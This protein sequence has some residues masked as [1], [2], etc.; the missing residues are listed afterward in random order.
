LE[1]NIKR[2]LSEI[3]IDGHLTETGNGRTD[4]SLSLIRE[5]RRETLFLLKPEDVNLCGG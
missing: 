2:Y 3:E 1:D 4:T 5:E